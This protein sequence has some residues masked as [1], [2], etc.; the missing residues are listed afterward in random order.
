MWTKGLNY[1]WE[2]RV[3]VCVCVTECARACVCQLAL[4]WTKAKLPVPV[5]AA[6]I[7]TRY[8]FVLMPRCSIS[9]NT[10]LPDS[11]KMSPTP[12][13][14][15]PCHSVLAIQRGKEGIILFRVFGSKQMKHQC[16]YSGGRPCPGVS[17]A[18]DGQLIA[19]GERKHFGGQCK[20]L[21]P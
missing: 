19:S 3:C 16:T 4:F 2:V 8:K 13:F 5:S 17:S 7:G 18:H 1:I 14:C 9:E 6:D 20:R 12:V 21:M 15:M 11:Q 10:T